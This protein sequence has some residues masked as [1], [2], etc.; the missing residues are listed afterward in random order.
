MKLV[1]SVIAAALLAACNTTPKS[2]VSAAPAV[3]SAMPKTIGYEA[4]NATATEHLQTQLSKTATVKLSHDNKEHALS[5]AETKNLLT[6]LD[7]VKSAAP[8][9]PPDDCIYL[10]MYTADG[11]WLMSLPVQNTQEGIVLLFLKLQGNN[12]GAPLQNWWQNITTR[13]SL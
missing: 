7:G 9:C 2:M 10:N 13:L 4:Y 8:K 1:C 5:A 6:L 11:E 12:A 3:T